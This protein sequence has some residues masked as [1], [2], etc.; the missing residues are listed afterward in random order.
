MRDAAH[1]VN[2]LLT[3]IRGQCS[4]ARVDSDSGNVV[5]MLDRFSKIDTAAV[6]CGA[7]IKK[8]FFPPRAMVLT[9]PGTFDLNELVKKVARSVGDELNDAGI[10]LTLA[11]TDQRIDIEGDA[12]DLNRALF[13]LCINARDAINAC[14]EVLTAKGVLISTKADSRSAIVTVQD[15][16]IGMPADQAWRYSI[17]DNETQRGHGL[18]IVR[19]AVSELRGW[20]DIKSEPLRG[21]SFSISLPLAKSM[22]AA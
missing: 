4:L 14:E 10:D 18:A 11:L 9:P 1:D 15:N 2:N 21:T 16:G 12:L 13:N 22:Q 19:R 6:S 20:I 8:E 3:V 5:R 17:D 7:I